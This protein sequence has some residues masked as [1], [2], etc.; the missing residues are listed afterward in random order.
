[1]LW[2]GEKWLR[3]D[4]FRQMKG[5]QTAWFLLKSGLYDKWSPGPRLDKSKQA[6]IYLCSLFAIPG[7]Q[8]LAKRQETYIAWFI[9]VK[10]ACSINPAKPD[11]KQGSPIKNC[12]GFKPRQF[13]NECYSDFLSGTNNIEM[14]FTQCL[15]F[16]L[17]NP[18]PRNTWPRCASQLAQT[19]SVRLPSGSGILFTAPLIS[20][21][22][23]GQPQCESNLL[24]D[25]YK[26]ALHLLQM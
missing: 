14:E 19:I 5:K 10:I 2:N 26:G 20:S 17:V 18:S 15:V 24:S 11:N 3:N 21:S 16:L 1:M 23:L 9:P 4:V 12:R 13:Y 8:F 7:I 25:L 22:K 6:V